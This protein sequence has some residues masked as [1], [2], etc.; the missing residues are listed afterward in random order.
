MLH[1]YY[2]CSVNEGRQLNSLQM[3]S[4]YQVSA[5]NF[6]YGHVLR[7]TLH[8]LSCVMHVDLL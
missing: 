5:Y 8:I 1:Y 6:S 4:L 2:L 7:L 3:M